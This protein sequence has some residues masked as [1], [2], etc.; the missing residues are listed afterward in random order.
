M[1]TLFSTFS[2]L[3]AEISSP[4]FKYAIA[5]HYYQRILI[6]LLTLQQES[7][8]NILWRAVQLIL[9]FIRSTSLYHKVHRQSL[10]RTSHVEAA[11]ILFTLRTSDSAKSL[12]VFYLTLPI[13]KRLRGILGKA[14]KFMN[15]TI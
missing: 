2:I 3:K 9:K 4:S 7:K 15:W 8:P 12:Y 6:V 11:A 14:Y 5:F 13:I 1:E 10:A